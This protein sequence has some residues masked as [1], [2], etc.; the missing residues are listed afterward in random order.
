MRADHPTLPQLEHR[1]FL[2]DSGLETT[3]I[4][5]DGVELREFAAFPL[6]ETRHGLDR[7]SDYFDAHAEIARQA[8]AGFIAESPTWRANSDWARKLGYDS[9]ALRMINRKAITLLANLR[10]LDQRGRREYVISGCIGPR[11]DGYNASDRMSADDAARY[12]AEQI[13][14]FADTSADLVSAL[15]MTHIEEAIGITRAAR[16]AGLPAVISFT[17]ETDGR[18]PSGTTL[19]DAI[20]QVDAATDHGPAYYMINCAHPAHFEPALQA[21][22]PWLSRVRGIRA[23]ASR[24]SHAQLDGATEL[25]AGDPEELASEYATLVTRFPVSRSSEAAAAPTHAT[26]NRSLVMH[27]L[28]DRRRQPN[29]SRLPR[30]VP[31]DR[32]QPVDWRT[33]VVLHVGEQYRGSEKLVVEKALGERPGVISVEANPTAPIAA[34]T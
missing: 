4:F 13:T 23:N 8:G 34:V 33:T 14:S 20:L 25:D 2:T 9:R 7:L 31:R 15:T 5:I 30:R 28:R 18:L 27:Y 12:H 17:V 6:L 21:N 22:T 10:D 1:P 11:G 24:Q 26:S 16:S 3:L 29:R 19:K 32:L